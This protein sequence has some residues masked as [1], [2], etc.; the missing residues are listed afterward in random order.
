MKRVLAAA[1]A[2]VLAAQ[3]AA[4]AQTAPPPPAQPPAPKTLAANMGVYVFP[5][6]GQS[7]KMQSQQ[8]AECYSWAVQ[9]F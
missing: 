6:E 2:I 4:F 9:K 8:E 5:T 7:A 3:S 1:V